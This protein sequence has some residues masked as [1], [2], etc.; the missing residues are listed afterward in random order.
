MPTQGAIAVGRRSSN[1]ATIHQAQVLRHDLY[2]L[3]NRTVAGHGSPPEDTGLLSG[4]NF[5]G[6]IR[7]FLWGG[8]LFTIA[9]LLFL[10]FLL[11]WYTKGYKLPP[12]QAEAQARA[13]LA[14][15]NR[16]EAKTR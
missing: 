4:T 2:G 15:L 10:Q 12:P 3:L 9:Y 6:L 7:G 14:Y 8:F 13:W 11:P 16:S 5:R 1:K